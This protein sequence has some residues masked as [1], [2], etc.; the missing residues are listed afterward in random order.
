MIVR[1]GDMIEMGSKIIKHEHGMQLCPMR[2][3][4]LCSLFTFIFPLPLLV[5]H[6]IMPLIYFLVICLLRR[7]THMK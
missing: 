6:N 7:R 3:C 4:V 5:P 2:V 1:D